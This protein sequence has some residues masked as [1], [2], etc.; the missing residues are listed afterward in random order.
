MSYGALIGTSF[1][2]LSVLFIITHTKKDCTSEQGALSLVCQPPSLVLTLSHQSTLLKFQYFE[3]NDSEKIQIQ[4]L[5][6]LVD[7]SFMC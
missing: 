1:I 6:L 3:V 7:P 4:L 2:S 5:T